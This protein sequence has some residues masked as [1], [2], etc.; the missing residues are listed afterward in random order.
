MAKGSLALADMKQTTAELV[1]WRNSLLL[2]AAAGD[3]GDGVTVAA[4]DSGQAGEA[5]ARSPW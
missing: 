4:V 1:A 5:V 2:A 3:G